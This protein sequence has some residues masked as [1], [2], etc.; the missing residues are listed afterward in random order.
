MTSIDVVLNEVS[1]AAHGVSDDQISALADTIVAARHIF[2][3]GAGRSGLMIRAFAN[4]LMHLGFSVSVVGE[5]SAP[6][7]QSGDLLLIGS[8]SGETPSL[9]NQARAAR[10]SEVTVALVT[11]SDHSTLQRLSDLAVVVPAQNKESQNA[12]SLQPMGSTFEQ[13]ALILYDALV[14]ELMR[15]TGQTAESMKARHANLE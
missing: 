11:A 13:T 12:S 1:T 5:V 4:R 7:T 14:L 15:R 3:S 9:I 10:S 8:G 6:H 2:V